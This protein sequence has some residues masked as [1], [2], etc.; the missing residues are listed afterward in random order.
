MQKFISFAA[1]KIDL[2]PSI[3]VLPQESFKTRNLIFPSDAS[4]RYPPF[5]P[6]SGS[7]DHVCG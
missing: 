1:I 3:Q 5:D 7:Y 4:N 6:L 2:D